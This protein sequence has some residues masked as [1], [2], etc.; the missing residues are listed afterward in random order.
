MARVAVENSLS[1]IKDALRNNGH[2][3]TDMSGNLDACDCCVISGEDKDVMGM[4]DRAAK[5]SVINAQG[6]T[7]DEV[8]RRVD[9]S[10]QR[11]QS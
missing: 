3:V 7:A 9:E 10:V 5:A 6:M 2:E 11:A 8:V 1:N 4:A